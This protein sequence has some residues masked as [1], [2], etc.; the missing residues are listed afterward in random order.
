MVAAMRFA[1]VWSSG[2]LLALALALLGVN[3]CVSIRRAQARGDV[4][5]AVFAAASTLLLLALLATVRAHERAVRRRRGQLK[6]VAWALS[7]A[8]T[9][10]LAHRI[11]ALAPAPSLAVVVWSM[12][13]A[14]VGAGFY[15]LFFVHDR[16]ALDPGRLLQDA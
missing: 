8:L 7:S 15:L 14:T 11:A 3:S 9:V 10:M 13:A 12:A 4:S 6:A 1:R 2:A 5:S 16:V